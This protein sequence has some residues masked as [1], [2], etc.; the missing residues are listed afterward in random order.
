MRVTSI[1]PLS[2]LA[3]REGVSEVDW[4]GLAISPS[5][6]RDSRLC[7]LP[8]EPKTG[9]SR[10]TYVGKGVINAQWLAQADSYIA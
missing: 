9:H 6:S 5:D 7:R 2:R 10:S 4:A 1:S 3:G 8:P